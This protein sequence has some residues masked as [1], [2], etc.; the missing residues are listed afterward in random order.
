MQKEKENGKTSVIFYVYIQQRFCYIN[1]ISKR[2]FYITEHL[3]KFTVDSIET[4]IK[5]QLGSGL[6]N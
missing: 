6:S 2:G 5:L 3:Q 1:S 4:N